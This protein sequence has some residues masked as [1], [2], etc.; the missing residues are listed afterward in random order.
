M[1]SGVA[2]SCVVVCAAVVCGASARTWVWTGADSG[3]WT[4]A[5]NWTVDGAVAG[6]PPGMYVNPAGGEDK[7]GALDA[8]VVFGAVADGAATTVDLDGFWDVSN[9]VVTASAP[10]YT[11]GASDAQS[12]TIFP[13]GGVFRVESGA[14][15]PNVVAAFGFRYPRKVVQIPNDR[16]ENAKIIND[17]SETLTFQKMF[18]FEPSVS[19]DETAFQFEGGGDIRIAGLAKYKHLIYID[20]AQT[21]GAKIVWDCAV[22]NGW[23]INGV[24][25]IRNLYEVASEIEIAEGGVL[26]GYNGMGPFEINGTLLLSGD[27]T[28]LCNV[29]RRSS[30][31]VN[32]GN[33]YV[34]QQNDVGGLLSVQCNV[35]SVLFDNRYYGGWSRCGGRGTTIFGDR[36]A[37]RG[38]AKIMTYYTDYSKDVLKPT[39]SVSKIGLAGGQS[40]LGYAGVELANGGRL[41]YTGGGETCTKPFCITNR[42]SG[43][44]NASVKDGTPYGVLEQ[45]GTGTLVFNS[46]VTSY[47]LKLDGETVVDATLELANSTEQEAEIGTTLADNV[48]SGRLNL[49]KTGTGLWRIAAASTYTGSTAIEG[50]TLA[51]GPA[52]SIASSSGVALKGAAR[53]SVEH[54]G[55]GTRTVALPS[56]SATSSGNSISVADGVAVTLAGLSVASGATLD[57]SLPATSQLKVEGMSSLPKG[58]TINKEPVSLDENG[59]LVRRTYP[60]DVSIAARGGRIPNAA[61]S[62]VG[63][64]SSGSEA[65]GPITLADG[66]SSAAVS[67]LAQ[68]TATP[69]TVNLG[70]GQTLAAGTVAISSGA[71]ALTIGAAVG[72]G[73]L[74]AASGASALEFDNSSESDL[75]VLA[76]LSVPVSTS[77]ENVGKGTTRLWWPVN[78]A[79]N[80]L[81]NAEEATLAL[82]NESDIA[83]T[84]TLVGGGRL[85][86]EGAGT[87][88]MSKA[89]DS[90]FTGDLEIAGG[91]VKA[92]GV[93]MLGSDASRLVV[94]NGGALHMTGRSEFGRSR[95]IHLSGSGADGSGALSVANLV[96]T[97]NLTLDGD[98][99]TTGSNSGTFSLS[100]ASEGGMLNMNGHRLIKSGSN[101]YAISIDNPLTVTNAGTIVF[102]PFCTNGNFWSYL[103]IRAGITDANGGNGPAVEMSN[104]GRILLGECSPPVRSS[105]RIDIDADK[106]GPEVSFTDGIRGQ[107][108]G[109]NTNFANWAG[110]IEIVNAGTW[111][112]LHPWDE[113]ADRYITISGQ[114]SGEGGIAYGAPYEGSKSNSKGHII[115]AN[116]NNTYTGPTLANGASGASLSLFH[117]GSLPDW[118]KL[119][120]THGRIGLFVGE[121]LFSEEDVLAAANSDAKLNCIRD[122]EGAFYHPPILAVDTTYAE[123]RAFTLTLSDADIRREDGSFSVGHDGPGT[124]TVAGSWTKPVNFGCYD[125]V[126]AFSGNERIALGAGTISGNYD[127]SSGEVLI[128]NVNR[129]DLGGG[130]GILIGGYNSVQ[131]TGRMTIRNSNIIRTM[132]EG[133]TDWCNNY[134]SI[135]VGCLGTGTL[136]I[137]GD[138]AITNHNVVGYYRGRGSLRKRG[139]YLFDFSPSY[140]RP[141]AVGLG[142]YG[143]FEHTGGLYEVAGLASVGE[144]ANGQ[145]VFV[146]KGGCVLLRGTNPEDHRHTGAWSL[147][148]SANTVAQVLI[149]GGVATNFCDTAIC[150]AADSRT[151]FTVTGGEYINWR[152]ANS[153]RCS[154]GDSLTVFNFNGGVFASWKISKANK[155]YNDGVKSG[156]YANF[157]GGTF[158]SMQNYDSLFGVPNGENWV[159]AIDRVTVYA[160]G[161]TIDVPIGGTM[162]DTS[163]DVPLSAPTGLGV[164]S[165]AWVDT[166]MDYVG[167]PV[168]EIIGDGTG[169]SAMAEFDSVNGK[170]TG[171][172][173]TG[174]GCDYTWAK[175]VIRYGSE[176]APVT[177]AAV[178]LASFQS[179]GLTKTGA[180][181]LSLNV[182]NTYTGPT[183]IE[184]GELVVNVNGAI[185]SGSEI[186]LKGGKLTVAS[187]V[188][189]PSATFRFDLLATAEY[190]EAFAFPD[191]AKIAFDNLDKADRAVGSYTVATFAG[192]LEGELPEIANAG[193]MPYGWYARKCGRSIKVRYARGSVFSIR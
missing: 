12:L 146:L 193:D 99:R 21:N 88:T 23:N 90:T 53:L 70:S 159:N 190:P 147:G 74:A 51:I 13:S 49:K 117:Y 128:E 130:T 153:A 176:V 95:E 8:S 27:G 138:C 114:I 66:L 186:V 63:I 48:D 37:M 80:L 41:L 145:G 5:A 163:V 164:K 83:F 133:A 111:L 127:K 11:F 1:R 141:S 189:L 97:P 169:A 92:S 161:A 54:G 170:V 81:L 152:P 121:G 4:N 173:V 75:T 166:G 58:V 24:R 102:E 59:L 143:H 68:Q 181:K 18:F 35:D 136:T 158:R 192:G 39:F 101:A 34:D 134:D 96:A 77:I 25:K 139:G 140:A 46:S 60:A 26:S 151:Y 113:S 98:V 71:E 150:S 184:D 129:V 20:L 72:V 119:E 120:M 33:P 42:V 168:V 142:G 6:V 132:K 174:H 179:G 125:G 45:G 157:N 28:Y 167:A 57:V 122:S 84:S 52:G 137:E 76:S 182:A 29:G 103:N 155:T 31:V 187:G 7:I 67:A 89:Q 135:V 124:L 55:S 16:K 79:G 2:L 191:G 62:I 65:D 112:A 15:V 144:I 149:A 107:A 116:P 10:R 175:A 91:T 56:V 178:T 131:S 85:R 73:T 126:L 17:S 14:P 87:W 156:A 93:K 100:S 183:V 9:L 106:S 123:G 19:F 30:A 109:V 108:D 162:G 44:S 148:N 69:A 86:K 3:S 40:P 78:W 110:P 38:S 160:G 172:T 104:G 185:P 94:T 36:N 177:N 115:F 165:V 32:G 64:T 180:G 47:G 61:N 43:I 154:F 105:L 50:G 82:T 118:S 188:S 22:T 171:I